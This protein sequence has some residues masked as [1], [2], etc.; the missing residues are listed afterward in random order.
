LGLDDTTGTIIRIPIPGVP[1][2]GGNG[3]NDVNAPSP[4]YVY[5]ERGRHPRSDVRP[6]RSPRS[7]TMCEGNYSPYPP[8][9]KC[10]L[11]GERQWPGAASKACIYKCPGWGAPVTYTQAA[12]HPCMGIKDNGEVDLSQRVKPSKPSAS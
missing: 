1:D 8:G 7:A 6:D 9:Q 5:P 12:G 4:D 2:L 11:T 3:T 10:Q